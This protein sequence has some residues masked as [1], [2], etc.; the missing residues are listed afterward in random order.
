L[1]NVYDI[2]DLVRVQATF[3]GSGGLA[4]PSQVWFLIRDGA[5][6]NAT[7][8]YGLTPSAI[9][10]ATVGGYYIDVDVASSVGDWRYRWEGTGNNVQVAEESTFNARRTFKL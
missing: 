10:R 8:R 4:D 7:H 2:G 9:F 5:G 1:P 3:L 6:N